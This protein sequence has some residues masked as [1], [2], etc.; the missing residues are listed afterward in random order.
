[1]T[2]YEKL[3]TYWLKTAAHDYETME[4]LFKAK[5]YA[6]ALFFGH[7]VLEKALKAFFV[8]V[9]KKHA[10]YTHNLVMLAKQTGLKFDEEKLQILSEINRF[11]MR[12][13]YPDI[14]LSFYKTA[15]LPYTRKY[16]VKIRSF[17]K[18]LCLNLK[19]LR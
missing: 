9:C 4:S 18:F 14:K 15:T 19:E 1:M 13:R 16:L 8:Q 10:P 6:D 12:A 3:V 5:R 2:D 17:Y 11:N 7:L